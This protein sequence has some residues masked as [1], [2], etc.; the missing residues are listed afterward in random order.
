[1][2]ISIKGGSQKIK[3]EVVV[4]GDKVAA[5]HILYFS[6]LLDITIRIENFPFTL[7]LTNIVNEIKRNNLSKVECVEGD[8]LL[9]CSQ[10]KTFYDLSCLNFNRSSI[11]LVSA[12]ANRNGIAFFKEV[13]GCNFTYRPIDGHLGLIEAFGFKIEQMNDGFI[14]K[15]NKANIQPNKLFEFD[16]LVKGIPSIGITCHAIIGFVYSKHKFLLLKNIA[17]EPTISCLLELIVEI[18][19]FYIEFN[20]LDRT[21]RIE[22]K[23]FTM[24]KTIIKSTIPSDFSYLCT[25]LGLGIAVDNFNIL[26][27]PVTEIP[28]WLVTLFNKLKLKWKIEGKLLNVI[29]QNLTPIEKLICSPWPGI[30]S[31]VGPILFSSFLGFDGKFILI[32]EIYDERSSHISELKEMGFNV[33]SRKNKVNKEDNNHLIKKMAVVTAKD[34]RCGASL[35]IASMIG[36]ERTTQIL[37]YEQILRGYNFLELNFNNL[38][39][40]Y[41]IE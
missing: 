40:D 23:V 7:E 10:N 9:V 29:G 8:A 38:D 15:P 28:D 13:G 14:V 37:N 30:P 26:F 19:G 36:K 12:I 32:D 33:S 3:G 18:F 27:S 24:S 20:R 22:K 39:I 1:M 17:V 11:C 5:T 21:I 16:C 31:D 2:N 25:F 34:I 41:T 4:Q 6:L 35:M